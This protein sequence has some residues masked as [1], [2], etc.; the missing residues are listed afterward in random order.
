MMTPPK[1]RLTYYVG[2]RIAGIDGFAFRATNNPLHEFEIASETAAY[3]VSRRGR[4][5]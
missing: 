2:D 5:S 1:N 3:D 4:L